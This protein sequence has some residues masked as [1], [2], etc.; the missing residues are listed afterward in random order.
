[1]MIYVNFVIYCFARSMD[2]MMNARGSMAMPM[3][4]AIVQMCLTI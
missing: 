1:M 3:L 4:G 2:F